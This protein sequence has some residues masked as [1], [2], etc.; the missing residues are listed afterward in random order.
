M[1]VFKWVL[2]KATFNVLHKLIWDKDK[3]EWLFQQNANDAD[4]TGYDGATLY[5][6]KKTWANNN[7]KPADADI[8]KMY[9]NNE[10]AE[11]ESIAL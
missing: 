3:E 10:T 4:E 7:S 8:V 9:K 6:S 5:F 11:L 2:T 1:M